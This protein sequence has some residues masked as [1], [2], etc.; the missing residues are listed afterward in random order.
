MMVD[1]LAQGNAVLNGL[2]LTGGALTIASVAWYVVKWFLR[3]QKIADATAMGAI[4]SHSYYEE[5]ITEKNVTIAR[6]EAENE[7]LSKRLDAVF[8]ERNAALSEDG[9]KSF[10]IEILTQQVE[11]LKKQVEALEKQVKVMTE[12][13]QLL[14]EKLNAKL[15]D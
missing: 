11:A 6:L 12:Q 5:I 3:S 7:R 15:F 8:D 2:G 1:E 9:K 13:T 10:Q 4:K 14:T